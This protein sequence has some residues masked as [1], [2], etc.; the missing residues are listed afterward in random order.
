MSREGLVLM[1]VSKFK[2]QLQP[3]HVLG[4]FSLFVMTPLVC[5][6]MGWSGV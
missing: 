6:N 1:F 5:G 4:E 2:E 3:I